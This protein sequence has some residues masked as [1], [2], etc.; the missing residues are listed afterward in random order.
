M[1][2]DPKNT[3]IYEA[4]GEHDGLDPVWAEKNLLR[5]ILTNAMCDLKQP[6]DASRKALE[7]FLSPDEDYIFS[8]RSVCSYLNIDADKILVV[9]GL[10]RSILRNGTAANP[11][12]QPVAGE[13]AIGAPEK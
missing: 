3:A 4:F 6:G 9:T 12:S 8:F 11:A 5:A 1:F 10:K 2:K 13:D 7:Y